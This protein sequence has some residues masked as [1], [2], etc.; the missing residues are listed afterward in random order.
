MVRHQTLDHA[1]VT[2]EAIGEAFL[3]RHDIVECLYLLR[4]ER[5]IE[6]FEVA[7]QVFNFAS[8]D[9]G[10]DVRSLLKNVGNCD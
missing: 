3:E 1:L 8:P 2:Y 5:D 9:D 10:E 6:R 7:V 4:R